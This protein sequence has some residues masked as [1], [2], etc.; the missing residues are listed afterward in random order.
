MKIFFKALCALLILAGGVGVAW[1]FYSNK[2]RARKTRPQ[3][4]IPLVQTIAV[5]P[6]TES[7]LFET[8]GTVIPA[9]K[10][11]VSTEVEGRILEQNE[12][13]VPG[14]IIYKD[15]LL[16]RLDARD[17]RFQVR[18]REA[19]L[20]TAEYELAVERGKQAVARQEWKILAKQMNQAEANRDLA[21][22]K[23]HLR[24]VQAQ[25]AAA[26]TR[27]EAA[28]LD[29]ARTSIYAPFTGIFLEEDVE[30]G[31]FIG[32]Q[33]A[34]ATLVSTEAFWVQVAVPLFLL[35]RMHFP[36]QEGVPGSRVEII[37][38]RGQGSSSVIRQG[39]VF[40]LLADLDPK[41]RM[42]RILVSL[43][44]PLCLDQET[45]ETT[46]SPQEA[47]LLG[48][49]VRVR[50]EAGQLEQI[51]VLPE[52][53]LREDNRLWVVNGDGV[54][55]FRDAQVRWRRVGEVLVEAEIA[56]DERIVI[57][58]LQ[59]PIPGMKVREEAG[60]DEEKKPTE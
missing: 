45:T 27:L 60:E 37:L 34:L 5:Q 16:V 40:K 10:L 4:A 30:Q 17:Y 43:P 12:K 19:E 46:C 11:V 15:E 28:K 52:K 18:E 35:E 50:M 58:R 48:S 36:E 26:K 42:A 32:R 59:S 8:S 25:I 9:R 47:I 33:S 1:H 54:L 2:P 39:T 20:S 49:F 6:S 3:R 31:Q 22:R 14:G 57:S 56:P 21:L 55:S 24:H 13:L 53:A 29:E 44:D 38:E 51:F 41:G 7:V 23:P